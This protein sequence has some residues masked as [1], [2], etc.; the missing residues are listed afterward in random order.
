VGI[1]Q[2]AQTPPFAKAG[3]L[4]VPYLLASHYF[5]HLLDTIYF[6]LLT[7]LLWSFASRRNAP[8]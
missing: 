2:L 6:T 3:T 7:L 8:S 1:G 4:S 5:E